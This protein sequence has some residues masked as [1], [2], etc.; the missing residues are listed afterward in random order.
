MDL[1]RLTERVVLV[2]SASRNAVHHATVLHELD[3]LAEHLVGQ[4]APEVRGLK[5]RIQELITQVAPERR[6][7][8]LYVEFYCR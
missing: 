8:T 6:D 5:K 4:S 7:V 3:R 1:I 2:E